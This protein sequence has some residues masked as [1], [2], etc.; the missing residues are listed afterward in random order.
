VID[1]AVNRY[2]RAK[3]F[4]VDPAQGVSVLE[5]I[6]CATLHGAYAGF[7]ENIK[8]SLEPG[9]LADLIVLSG[10]ILSIPPMGINE[11]RVDLTMIDGKIEY[12]RA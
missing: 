9:T 7:E 11:L 1:G 5:A 3:N 12:E 8:G 4:Q 10:D 6:R 2:D